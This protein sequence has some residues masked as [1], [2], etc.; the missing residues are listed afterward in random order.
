MMLMIWKRMKSPD[1]T[2]ANCENP[3]KT[4]DERTFE[5]RSDVLDSKSHAL[6]LTA[7]NEERSD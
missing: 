1:A 6:I 2:L 3:E 7:R 5:R 4:S